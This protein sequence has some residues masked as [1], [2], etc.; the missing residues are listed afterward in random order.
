MDKEVEGH[1]A[2]GKGVEGHEAGGMNEGMEL[3]A[4]GWRARS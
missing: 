3:E 4:R 2:E 1:E